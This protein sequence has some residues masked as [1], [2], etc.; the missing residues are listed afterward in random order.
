MSANLPSQFFSL[1]A[2]LK[3]AKTSE[4]KISILK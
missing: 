3:E 2:K 1:S 4:E